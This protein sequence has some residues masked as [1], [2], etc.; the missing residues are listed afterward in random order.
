MYAAFQVCIAL[1]T[2]SDITCALGPEMRESCSEMR[3]NNCFILSSTFAGQKVWH[4][5]D[6]SI[7][8]ELKLVR[9][10][11]FVLSEIAGQCERQKFKCQ[12]NT[13]INPSIILPHSIIML[14]VAMYYPPL[15][16]IQ[17]DASISFFLVLVPK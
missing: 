17:K 5:K 7:G 8:C 9:W 14:D 4:L 16:D 1:D 13:F 12:F 6:F 3:R 15:I 11:R 2:S 10:C